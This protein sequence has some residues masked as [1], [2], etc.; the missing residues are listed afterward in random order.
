MSLNPFIVGAAGLLAG[1]V[2]GE[3]ILSITLGLPTLAPVFLTALQQQDS[4]LAGS[5]VLI[6]SGL[7]VIGILL[8]DLLL[9]VVDPRIRGSV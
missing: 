6:L 8:S 9:A 4:Q 2:S 3:V 1:L 7:T 5:I